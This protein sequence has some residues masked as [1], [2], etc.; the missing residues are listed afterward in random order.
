MNK[1][2]YDNIPTAEEFNRKMN[3]CVEYKKLIKLQEHLKWFGDEID[4]LSIITLKHKIKQR[5]NEIPEESIEFHREVH[6]STT[7]K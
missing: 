2:R 7:N 3:E 1:K 6:G 4:G 5:I